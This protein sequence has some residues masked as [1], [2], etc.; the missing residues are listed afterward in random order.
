MPDEEG[1]RKQLNKMEW[2]SLFPFK[3]IVP[4]DQLDQLLHFF[5]DQETQIKLS[6]KGKY[7]SVSAT[8]YLLNPDKVFE[9]YSKTSKIKGLITF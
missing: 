1:L 6:S 4:I 9:M 2:P 3:F 5:L 8:P 7:A